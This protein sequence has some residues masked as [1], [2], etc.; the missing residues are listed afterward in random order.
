MRELAPLLIPVRLVGSFA[1]SFHPAQLP[2]MLRRTYGREL[3]SWAFLPLMLGAIE[4]GTIGIVVKKAFTGQ[5]GVDPAWLDLATA[6]A[7]AAPN[8]ANIT[9]FIWAALARG[10]PKVAFIAGL[11]LSTCL[12]VALIA[13]FPRNGLGLIAVCI[14]LGLAR[15]AWTGV[16]TIRAAVWR[17]NYPTASRA[18]IA[19][20]L[21]TVQSLF[22]AAA[23]LA[24]GKAMDWNADN[25]HYLFPMLAL[26]GLIGNQ[27]YASVRLR[28]ARQLQRAELDGRKQREGFS[29]M[30][31]VR[32]LQ[33]DPLYARFMW[34]MSVF[35]FGNLLMMAPMTFVVVD[36]LQ[37]SYT[38]GVMAT[39]IVPLI[40]LTMP[41]TADNPR[42]WPL[43]LV[44]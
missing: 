43:T 20:K 12:L 34:W 2:P 7:V 8:V 42:P 28:R 30:A 38:G 5:P 22:L 29:P 37:M 33:D 18:A 40:L 16:I 15:T 24:V 19:G 17:N 11:Q 6:W 26:F 35:G 39:T 13:F 31:M 4:G 23:G 32:L 21:A 27:I 44:V 41:S 36:E 10:R 14:T 1:R 3:V 25:Y 9:S